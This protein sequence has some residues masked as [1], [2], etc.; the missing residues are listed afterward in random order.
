[1]DKQQKK[2]WHVQPP[3]STSIQTKPN[4]LKDRDAKTSKL[5]MHS[6]NY[7]IPQ[8]TEKSYWLF[9]RELNDLLPFHSR[10]RFFSQSDT[11]V[12][13]SVKPNRE[14]LFWSLSTRILFGHLD[15]INVIMRKTTYSKYLWSSFNCNSKPEWV[16]VYKI[17]RPWEIF[18][19][20]RDT[21]QN[22]QKL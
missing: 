8:M 9:S 10:F 2:K 20:L 14:S 5:E 18:S 12:Y 21:Q 17:S 13:P 22:T 6:W 1:M 4:V 7:L 19:G 15:V 3:D 16:H 11:S